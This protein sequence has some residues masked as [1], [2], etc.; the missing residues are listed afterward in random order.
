MNTAVKQQIATLLTA[1]DPNA[2]RSAAEDLTEEKDSAANAALVLAL[3]DES[4]GVQDAAMHA[5]IEIGDKDVARS[6][7][8]PDR[9]R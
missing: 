6:G 7:C 3:E 8:R 9:Q 4:K 5:L 1:S 2:R